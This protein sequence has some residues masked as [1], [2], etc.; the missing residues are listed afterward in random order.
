ME[1]V[2]DLA[3]EALEAARATGVAYE[4]VQGLS[5]LR[6]ALLS[7]GDVGGSDN[8]A[9]EY[10]NLVRSV[11]LPRF[12]AGLE[13]RR[14]MRA[15]LSGRFV[16]AEAHANETVRLQ[17]TQEFMEGFAVQV[18]ASRFEQGRLNE[19]REVIETWA[20]ENERAAWRI[21]LGA[22]LAES[23]EAESAAAALEEYSRAGFQNV[24][25]DDLYFLSLGVAAATAYLVRDRNAAEA[26]YELLAPQASRVIIAA[27]G[28]LCWGSIHRFLGPLSAILGNTER[29]SMHFEAAMSVHERLGARSFLARDRLTYATVLRSSGGDPVRIDDLS[30][31]G[32]ALATRLGMSALVERFESGE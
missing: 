6:I 10:E 29:A 18:F 2:V 31:T 16:E 5:T 1:R 26:L 25:R 4:V 24:P 11:R 22:L 20:A 14:A 21:G 12:M 28:V 8:V 30:R 9:R 15:L 17:P 7:A 3:R 32:L 27:E 23:G 19:V 13:Q